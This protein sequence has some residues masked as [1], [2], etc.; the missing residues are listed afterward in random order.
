ML[1][2]VLFDWTVNTI[3]SDA[4]EEENDE[5]I[6]PPVKEHHLIDSSS[7]TMESLLVLDNCRFGEEV[8]VEVKIETCVARQVEVERTTCRSRV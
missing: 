4:T 1:E 7:V 8:F 3:G 6:T 2:G 5:L